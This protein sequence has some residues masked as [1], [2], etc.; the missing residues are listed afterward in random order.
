[1]EH[2]TE[3]APWKAFVRNMDFVR[4]RLAAYTRCEENLDTDIYLVSRL[5]KDNAYFNKLSYN[6]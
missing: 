2:E 5:R 4:K 3:Y 6:R 1:M